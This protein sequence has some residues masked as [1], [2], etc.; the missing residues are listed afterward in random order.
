MLGTVARA[1]T[2]RS[3]AL[4]CALALLATGCGGGADESSDLRLPAAVAERLAKTSDEIAG[5]L[6]AGDDCAAAE[7][8]A[9]LEA[10]AGA[11]VDGGRVPASFAEPLLEAV[12]RLTDDIVCDPAPLHDEADDD[13]SEDSDEFVPPGKAKGK[14]KGNGKGKGKG[15][16]KGGKGK[17]DDR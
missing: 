10:R 14:D 12:G 3:G 5:R 8:A 16:G 9:D 15:H 7:L 6:E 11:A 2:T 17:E 1:R 13:D 4:V